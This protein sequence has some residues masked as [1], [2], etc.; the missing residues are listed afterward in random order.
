MLGL[1]NTMNQLPGNIKR[2]PGC[3]S[4]STGNGQGFTL[5]ELLVVI[6]I[7]AILAALLLPALSAAKD[8]AKGIKCISNMKQLQLAA[9][10]YGSNN[11]DKM[12][13]NVTLGSGVAGSPNWVAGV[14]ASPANNG[15]AEAPSGCAINP[16][17]LG[18]QGKTGGNPVVTLAGTIGIYANAA[19]VYHCP[20]DTYIDPTWH[21]LRVR[22]CSA[23]ANVDGTGAGNGH[24]TFPKFSSFNGNLS[25][26]DCF[27]F[28][29]ENP[30]SLNDGW[31]VFNVGAT[32]TVNDTPAVNHGKFSSLSF[33]DGHAELHEWHGVFLHDAAPGAAGD[34]D[35]IWMAQ[36][37][38]Y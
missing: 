9:I 19:D 18:V 27:V 30:L 24:H 31:F 10:L 26:S 5:I 36:H 17:Y 33:A 34:A 38:T 13:A 25:A 8:R 21:K 22:S 37:G 20:A 32:P 3:R 23:N 6:A 2:G 12:P 15:V 16:F 35:T 14:F 28:L 11:E 7:I 29:D 1:P 4:A